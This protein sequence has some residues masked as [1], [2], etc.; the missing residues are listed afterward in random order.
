MNVR[1][2]A[3]VPILVSAATALLPGSAVAARV[4]S[5]RSFAATPAAS[6]LVHGASLGP[7]VS[8]TLL[9]VNMAVWFDITQPRI[10]SAMRTAGITAVRWPGGSDSDDYHWK[11]NTQCGGGY[12]NPNSTFDNFMTDVAKPAGFDVSITLNYGSNAACN[13]G[14]DPAEA[15]AWVAYAK[16]KNYGIH[17]WTVGNEEYG[18]WEED[19]HAKAHDPGTYA[20]AVATG[21]YP[22]IKAADPNAQVGV[23]VEGSAGWDQTVLADAKYD[24]VELHYYAQSPG[25]ESD[26]FLLD[27][28]PGQLAS[29]V[30]ALRS[31]LV[32]AG[33]GNVPIY[34]GEL[35]SVYSNPGKQAQ[36]IVQALFAGMTL[37]ELASLNVFR[38]TWWIGYGGCGDASSGNFSSSLYGWQNFGGYMI[39]SDG[40]PEYGCPNATKLPQGVI[41]PT[42][43]AYEVMS[44]F[45]RD[46]E[47]MATVT[48]GG[49]D[50]NLRAYAVSRGTSYAVALFNLS[51]TASLTTS[52][53]ID[54]LAAGSSL[55]TVSYDKALYDLSKH[56]YYSPPLR[57]SSGAWHG[58]VAL[59]LPPWSMTVVTL[60]P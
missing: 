1:G 15:A 12:G 16:S 35:G 60:K 5:L 34:L 58:P 50:G 53:T 44:E 37:D 26:A 56:N 19:L 20:T 48:L 41:L 24:F 43:R 8:K 11:N 25:A 7:S 55:Q 51:E 6:V 13:A 29:Q 52:V 9:G 57:T 42:A 45:I 39:F 38:A 30:S 10:T 59:T 40:L 49:T 54:K 36:S 23:V 18:S 32:A 4:H 27:D 46:G 14:G 2:Y 33:R 31:E 28:A 22:Q 47:S 3:L 21:Y 17:Y